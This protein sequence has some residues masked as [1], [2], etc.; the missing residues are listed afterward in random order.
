[1]LEWY[2]IGSLMIGLMLL[3]MFIGMPA[4]FAMGLTS[5]T[6]I[7][8]FISPNNLR[9]LANIAIDRGSDNQF[10]VAPLFIFMASLVAYSG[11][12][13]DAYTAAARWLNRLP[14]SLAV[15][16]TAACAAFAG[17]SGSSVADALTVGT[18]AIPQMVK[19]GYDKRLAVGSVATAGTLGILIPPSI[20]MVIFGII[21]ETSIGQLFIA[22]IVPGI[23]LALV[24]M[25]YILVA[26]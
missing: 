17:V 13:E 12:A 19:H 14:G 9:V 1:M 22:G 2:S 23:L 6:M 18:F 8:V 15:S 10:I 24:L 16:S 3:L 7:A 4:G 21:T 5:A 25:G 20:S 11:V 26:A